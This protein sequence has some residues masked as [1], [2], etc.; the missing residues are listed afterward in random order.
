MEGWIENHKMRSYEK[1]EELL[2][3]LGHGDQCHC[4]EAGH[5]KLENLSDHS[6]QCEWGQ[7]C[8]DDNLKVDRFIS[9]WETNGVS[10]NFLVLWVVGDA[11]CLKEILCPKWELQSA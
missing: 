10:T 7:M 4:W 1:I 5:E 11:M 2:I 3:T 9:L 8:L 6:M